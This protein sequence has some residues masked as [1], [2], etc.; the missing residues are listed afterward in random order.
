MI[1]KLLLVAAAIAMPASAGAVALVSTSSVAG[2]NTPITCALT[3]TVHFAAPGISKNGSLTTA[4]TT[5]TTTTGGTLSGSACGSTHAGTLPNE[6][7]KTA[8]VKCTGTHLPSS[9]PACVSG[10]RGYDSWTN[11]ANSGT[12]SIAASIPSIVIHVG[13]ST[14]T[15][16]TT[17]AAILA[18]NAAGCGT[19]T[20]GLGKEVGFKISGKVT[21]AGTYLNSATTIKICLGKV[22]GNNLVAAHAPATVPTFLYQVGNGANL[23]KTTI[24]DPAH[25]SLNIA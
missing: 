7:I 24:I 8:T 18:A 1:R 23:V 20:T 11:Y 16:H 15:S 6:T 4:M 5:S 14:Y 21:T 25:S 17:G 2:A 19:G 13:S 12:S 22:T 10:K 9:N 3:G